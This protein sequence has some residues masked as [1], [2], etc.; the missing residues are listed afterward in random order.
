MF[1]LLYKNKCYHVKSCWIRLNVDFQCIKVSYFYYFFNIIIDTS[2]DQLLQFLFFNEVFVMTL[3]MHTYMYDN[4]TL[5]G[6]FTNGNR[7][8]G[9]KERGVAEKD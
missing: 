3:D 7:S 9:I 6:I 2:V 8:L 1:L 4:K 5:L